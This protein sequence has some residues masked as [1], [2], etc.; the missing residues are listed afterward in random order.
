MKLERWQKAKNLIQMIEKLDSRKF[1]L[2]LLLD[3]INIQNGNRMIY[4]Y[5]D[6][7]PSP[8]NKTPLYNYDKII[9]FV[10]FQ[11]KETEELL[12]KR[13]KEFDEL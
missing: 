10:K 7:Y 11:I 6:N 12:E 3:S 2:I 9:E 8:N 5:M 13:K 1:E 4:I